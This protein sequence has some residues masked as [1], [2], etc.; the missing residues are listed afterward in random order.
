MINN[1][2]SLNGRIKLK[3]YNEENDGLKSCRYFQLE[4]EP[5]SKSAQ[6]S[7]KITSEALLLKK[8][9]QVRPQ[10][11]SKSVSFDLFCTTK[12]K[13]TDEGGEV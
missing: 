6:S 7:A 8:I 12:I 13:L 10:C 3:F 1:L 2:Q 4:N 11:K 9:L 5:Y